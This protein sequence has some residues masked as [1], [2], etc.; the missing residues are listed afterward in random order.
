MK[1]IHLIILFTT[2]YILGILAFNYHL[3]LN[4]SLISIILLTILCLNF[5]FKIRYAIIGYLFF[6]FAFF[7][8]SVQL[9]DKDNLSLLFN[10]DAILQGTIS[11]IPSNNNFNKTSFFVDV[12]T[13]NTV[14]RSYQ[15]INSKLYLTIN[16]DNRQ[17]I[18]YQIGDRIEFKGKIKKPYKI[19]NP[20]QFNYAKFLKYKK[21]FTIMFIDEDDC[22]ITGIKNDLKWKFLRKINNLRLDIINKQSKYIKSPNIEIL[23]GIVFG[24]DAVNPPQ[25]IKETFVTTG[26]LH[27]LAASGM[28][29]AFIFSMMFFILTLFKIPYRI[30][31]ITSA[32]TIIIYAAMTGF[33]PSIIRALIMLE[34]VILG[35]LINK[36][37][38]SLSLLSFAALI[39]LIIS[40]AMLFNV[41]F[42]L[43]FIVTFGIIL[44]APLIYEFLSTKHK[45]YGKLTV[46]FIPIIAQIF[47]IPLQMYYFQT[48]STYSLFAN[49]LILPFLSIIS[50]LGFVNSILN[51]IPFFYDF[52]NLIFSYI[53]NPAISILIGI[54]KLFAN[55]DNAL[56]STYK[57]HFYQIIFYYSTI[58]FLYLTLKTNPRKI[59]NYVIICI[60]II[61]LC[62][63]FIKI[64]NKNF[65]TV[66]FDVQNGDCILLKTP[67][68]KYIMIDS[69]RLGYKTSY[70]QIKSIVIPYLKENRVKEIDTFIITHFDSDHAGGSIELLKNFKVKNV[71]IS[72]INGD[73][74]LNKNIKEY[75]LENQ[76]PYSV[77]KNEDTFYNENDFSLTN[78]FIETKNKNE[79]SIVTLAQYQN[80]KILFC[81]DVTE[82]V[83]KQMNLPKNI[84]VIKVGHHGAIDTISKEFLNTHN[85]KHAIISV[86]QNQYNHPHQ[87]TIESLKSN[88]TNIYRTD[89]DNAIKI[90]QSKKDF[91]IFLYSEEKDKWQKVHF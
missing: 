38:N 29:V 27:I 21:T 51:L 79:S 88:N 47:V 72:D 68:N 53:L 8:T 7:N 4:V 60:C 32:I 85:V 20:N 23:G 41:S 69:G 26:L 36:E 54:A 25:Y 62:F 35:K 37:A 71:I 10:K 70:S 56:L 74:I 49:I 52:I 80:Y 90:S 17:T 50:F 33:P 1:K 82:K 81:A 18:K 24:D 45:F 77:V 42:Q 2:L 14:K 91:S 43:S 28:N 44:F 86:G 15:D 78:F 22:K 67:Q 16:S 3:F 65:E 83:L 46:L 12:E 63:S 19:G 76:I 59:K 57:M 58:I 11:S 40:P 66:F 87:E 48:F 13:V 75:I 73:S 6:I 89:L 39:M 64:P 31:I 34:F 5:K 55:L 30:N 61:L 9:K 84:D